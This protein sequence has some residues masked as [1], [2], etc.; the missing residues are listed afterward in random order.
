[1]GVL[2]RLGR[3]RGAGVTDHACVHGC[4]DGWITVATGLMPC[5]RHRRTTHERWAAGEYEPTGGRTEIAA[6]TPTATARGLDAIEAIRATH[7]LRS[8]AA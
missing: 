7:H 1:M 4:D 5:P 8:T 2:R 6:P 3:R